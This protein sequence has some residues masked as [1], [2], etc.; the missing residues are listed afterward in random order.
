MVAKVD[1][2]AW[3]HVQIAHC[4]IDPAF[5]DGLAGFDVFRR[6]RFEL[7]LNQTIF[8]FA[9][10]KCDSSWVPGML[11]AFLSE[12]QAHPNNAHH[13]GVAVRQVAA[14]TASSTRP[15]LTKALVPVAV[16]VVMFP[17]PAFLGDVWRVVK[18]LKQKHGGWR[19]PIFLSPP[20]V[21]AG[22]SGAPVDCAF[23][24]EAVGYEHFLPSEQR[25]PESALVVEDL[26]TNSIGLAI[27]RLGLSSDLAEA[28]APDAN[29]SAH[30]A[31]RF[32]ERVLCGRGGPIGPVP[33]IKT[34]ELICLEVE[35]SSRALARPLRR[36]RPRTSWSYTSTRPRQRQI[37]ERACGSGWRTRSSQSM[38]ALDRPSQASG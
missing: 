32:Y 35:P 28:S 22:S 3:E 2:L 33:V 4:G 25:S 20:V 31:G 17:E 38:R 34:F 24:L 36:R 11:E 29:T 21:L 13:R 16:D 14:R 30:V 15:Q 12:T 8:W 9:G 26:A 23:V 10:A 6:A 1:A 18:N 37:V 19:F 5:V 7:E 27:S